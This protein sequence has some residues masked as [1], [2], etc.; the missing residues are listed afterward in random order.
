MQ[1]ANSKMQ[2]EKCKVQ[3]EKWIF[4]QVSRPDLSHGKV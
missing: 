2:I 1:N 3:I 4:D